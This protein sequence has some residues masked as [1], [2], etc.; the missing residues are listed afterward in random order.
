M[1]NTTRQYNI[2][3]FPCP[4]TG[5]TPGA[6]VH[7]E[8]SGD[9]KAFYEEVMEWI[10]E[11]CQY[12]N[13]DYSTGGR[14][15]DRFLIRDGVQEDFSVPCAE[16]EI[17]LS[18]LYCSRNHEVTFREIV[19]QGNH[20]T[21]ISDIRFSEGFHNDKYNMGS[22]T[23]RINIRL[24]AK[25]NDSDT[26]IYLFG[27]SLIAVGDGGIA[28]YPLSHGMVEGEEG[29]MHYAGTYC[30]RCY[31]EEFTEDWYDYSQWDDAFDDGATYEPVM[32]NRT[33]VYDYT[34]GV[35][36]FL[37]TDG[38]NVTFNVLMGGRLY[39]KISRDDEKVVFHS[40]LREGV[41]LEEATIDEDHEGGSYK[42]SFWE[43]RDMQDVVFEKDSSGKYVYTGDNREVADRMLGT[44]FVPPQTPDPDSL[45]QDSAYKLCKDYANAFFHPFDERINEVH[46]ALAMR[47][48]LR[49]EL[50]TYVKG[51]DMAIEKFVDGYIRY[52]LRGK[53]P[54]KPAGLYLFAGPPGTGKTY[55]AEAFSQALKKLTDEEYPY[56]RFDMAAYGG[57]GG[58][59]VT[60][61]VGFEKTWR[62]S[63]PG[64]LTD[65]VR[66]NPKCI[67][68]FDEIEK[69]G[70]QARFLFLSILEGAVLTDKYYNEQ[71]S[72]E[73]AILLFTTNEGKDLYEDNRGA[74]L[75]ALPDS[76]V[77]EGLQKSRFAPELISRFMS[78]TVIMFNHLGY[79]EMSDI[80]QNSVR[81]TISQ[82]S[83]NT[84]VLRPDYNDKLSRLYLLSK[85]DRIDARFVSTNARKMAEDYFLEAMEY[86]NGRFGP[87]SLKSLRQA[88][89]LV[90]VTDEVR[91][92]FELTERPRIVGYAEG[93]SQVSIRRRKNETEELRQIADCTWA[94]SAED[95]R[96][97]L[98]DCNWNSR[99]DR[100]DAVIIDLGG[101]AGRD[102]AAGGYRCLKA[103][104]EAKRDIPVIVVDRGI[105]A[106]RAS[107]MA[108]GVTDFV[109]G[110]LD[111]KKNLVLGS[112]VLEAVFSRQH[113]VNMA[114]ALVRKGQR[115]SAE[116]RYDYKKNSSKLQIHFTNLRVEEAAAEDAEARRQ[117][118]KYLLAEKPDVRLTDIFGNELVKT[119]VKRCIDNIKYPEKYRTAG[120]KLMTGI[121]M[122]GVPGMGKTMFAKAMSFES[123]AEFSSVAGSDFLNG[124]GVAKM[125]EMFKTAR[126]K[127]PC[128]LFIDEF[129][130]I[131]KCRGGRI[132]G[133]QEN[134][135][136]KFLKEMDGLGADNDGV[137]VAVATNYPLEGLDPAVTRRFSEKIFFPYPTLEEHQ[138]F[139]IEA[140]KKKNEKLNEKLRIRTSDRTAMT[141]S[142][143]MYSTR[144][145]YAEIEAFVEKS[146]AEAIHG[147]EPVTEKFLFDQ[148]H[149]EKDGAARQTA[150]M[151]TAFHEA[152][153]AVL[154]HHFQMGID[155][156]TIVSRGDYGGYSLRSRWMPYTG[157]DF[158]NLICISLAGRVAE[159]LYMQS[160]KRDVRF[161][162]NV[163]ASTDL[164]NAT[165]YAYNYVCR[166]GLGGERLMVVPEEFMPQTGG[167]PEDALPESEKEAIWASVKQLLAQQWE[168]TT[169][170]LQEY[171]PGVKALAWSLF[172]MQELDGEK[173]EG[174]IESKIPYVDETGFADSD[175][176]YR[177]AISDGVEIAFPFGYPIYPYSRIRIQP[178]KASAAGAD[179]RHYYYVIKEWEKAVLSEDLKEAFAVAWN[180]SAICRRFVSEKAAQEYMDMLE[181]KVFRQGK[182]HFCGFYAD[183]LTEMSASRA[184]VREL[185]VI[186]GGEVNWYRVKTDKA[187]VMQLTDRQLIY[188]Y[189]EQAAEAEMLNLA[190][191]LIEEM[192]E[193]FMEEHEDAYRVIQIYDK[194]LQEELLHYMGAIKYQAR[195]YSRNSGYG[196]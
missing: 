83:R 156:V 107:L 176:D 78:G 116:A 11:F 79:F 152:G 92:Y 26:L 34:D 188:R 4:G 52:R 27:P 137:Y 108:L 194:A 173:A 111:K 145:S 172:Y 136:E 167:Y 59:S 170:A 87:E 69:A 148:L 196:E 74:N 39:Q 18:L 104:V 98:V 190:R 165:R 134:V 41:L 90:D 130:A 159:M 133:E 19:Y 20:Y 138:A 81:E 126:R 71:V 97:R 84:L 55:L 155:Y 151:T 31:E 175:N 164:Q 166:Y 93:V 96:K 13:Y 94:D 22:D 153:H 35:E 189:Q 37:E 66:E 185:I 60:G 25:K 169:Q 114:T 120:V 160:T 76:A 80:F 163:G 118:R 129:D 9:F 54:G 43:C 85:G 135:L 117:N 109:P 50:K 100:Y 32:R 146:I 56:K 51:Q 68:L 122:Y 112:D 115:I 44:A 140:I 131:S 124:D 70:Q 150:S 187:G 45:N 127:R 186:K 29:R 183:A 174:V 1:D 142:R 10:S 128:I 195:R 193:Q 62:G 91:E 72:F 86:I 61:L 77:L 177:K 6:E 178:E 3:I 73:D 23:E 8:V 179:D 88:E 47:R 184:A 33:D 110:K 21:D 154:Q 2:S 82:I 141:L 101:K 143:M 49:K 75:T 42:P 106:E 17:I 171:W 65:F 168:Y 40:A 157:Q 30:Y 67:L 103:A 161:G 24:H 63:Q 95:F 58:D 99:E 7:M 139:L 144:R 14:N 15:D 162:I 89:I 149:N 38:K 182:E 181:L 28:G 12:R 57:E 46:A 113:F 121:L 191:W 16:E 125:E 147:N 119:A 36:V 102:R 5:D 53:V 132:T 64:Q 105:G 158:L 48:N 192:S 180:Q 123:G